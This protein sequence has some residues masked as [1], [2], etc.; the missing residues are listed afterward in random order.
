MYR[1]GIPK[2]Y[3]LD[4]YYKELVLCTKFPVFRETCIVL[5][6]DPS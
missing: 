3:N 2:K 5:D 6:V 4:T 1:W